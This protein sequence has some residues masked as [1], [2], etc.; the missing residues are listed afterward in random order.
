MQALMPCTRGAVSYDL[1][2]INCTARARLVYTEGAFDCKFKQM[3]E[4]M[5]GVT[6]YEH[7]SF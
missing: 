1:D 2:N 4:I 7:R 5:H 6:K 3:E